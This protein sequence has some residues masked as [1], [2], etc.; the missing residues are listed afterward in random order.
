MGRRR[1]LSKRVR[2]E[3]L[4]RD[5]FT[6]QYCGAKAPEVVLNVDHIQPVADGGSDDPLNLI[7]SCEDCNSGK[8]DKKL[9]DESAV[10]VARA[11][12]DSLQDRREM[13][14]M[15]AEWQN[16]L[17]DVQEQ[18][19]SEAASYYARLVPGH[20]LNEHGLSLL[21]GH[22]A[23]YGLQDVMTVMRVELPKHVRMVDGKATGESAVAAA[24]RL[25]N[26]L[27]Y[28]SDNERDPVG[29]ELRYI[30]G[31]LRNRLTYCPMQI[32]LELLREAHDVHG[33]SLSTLKDMACHSRSF[34]SWEYAMR[35]LFDGEP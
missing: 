6:C 25:F 3:V 12:S 14:E 22:V 1:S 20:V 24:T 21:R 23:K 7:A 13:I 15:M 16:G 35:K 2:F 8:S 34:T 19:T 4:K 9:S 29:A 18:A 30:R 10:A 28:K 27:K 11:Q 32:V 5:K 26:A 33:V 31:I 17:L